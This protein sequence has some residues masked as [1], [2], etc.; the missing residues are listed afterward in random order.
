[1]TPKPRSHEKYRRKAATKAP[2]ET[3]LIVCEGAKTEKMYFDGLRIKFRFPSVAVKV[4]GKECGSAPINV[5]DYA[6]RYCCD[7]DHC[8]CVMDVEAPR[9]HKTLKEA[10][11]KARDNKLNVALTNPCFEFWYILHFERYTKAFDTNQK[12]RLRLKRH[13]PR[14]AKGGTEIFEKLFPQIR[15]AVDNADQVLVDKQC[16]TNLS[17]HNPST[18]VHCLV[19]HLY[20]IADKEIE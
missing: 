20:Q 13:I 17:S 7:Y 10:L 3:V 4:C 8:W 2:L 18:H 16:G 12:V 15:T 5:V 1:M 6:L 9:P 11:C 19:K 14:Y